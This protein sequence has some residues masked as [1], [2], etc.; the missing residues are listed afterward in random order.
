MSMRTLGDD[1]VRGGQTVFHGLR[2]WGQL[3][4]VGLLLTAFLTVAVPAVQYLRTVPGYHLYAAGMLTLAEAKLAMGYGED[5][6]QE[7]LLENGG[8]AVA[9]L[10]DIAGYAPW[11]A[12]RRDILE[13]VR[14]GMWLG[15]RIGLGVVAVMLAWFR[16]QGSRLKRAKRVRGA[17]LV[18]ARALARRVRPWRERALSAVGGLPAP[19]R[20]AGVSYPVRAETQHTIVS[21]TTGSGKTVLISD[22]VQQIRD[23][24]ERCVIYD[25]MGSYT[26]A[27][28]DPAR[29]VLLNPL[30]ARAPRWSPFLEARSP[31]DFDT[32]AA[33]LI[34]QQKDTVDPFWVTA[35]RQ[36][37]ANGA[38]VL[39]AKGEE[40]N[41]ALVEHLLKTDL[42]DLAKAMEG[43]VAQSI[44]DPQNPKTALSVRAMLTANIGAMEVLADS[45]KH[46]SIRDWISSDRGSG[47]LFL[48]SR[49]DQHASLRG[50]ISTWLEIAVNSMLSLEQDEGRR[51]W[52]IL[53]ELPTLHQVP[54]LQPGLAESR[55][56]GGC[57]VLG[58]QVASALRDLYGRN[59]AET[60]SGLCGTRV[61]FAAPDRDTAQWS[62]DSLGRSEVEEFAEGVSYGA[63]PYRDGVT[64][65]PKR[66]VQALAL[67]SEIMRLPNLN[68]YLKLPGPFPVARIELEYVKREKVASRFVARGREAPDDADGESGEGKDRKSAAADAAGSGEEKKSK[69][70]GSAP[71]PDGEAPEQGSESAAVPPDADRESGTGAD[72]EPGPE[73][74]EEP[75]PDGNPRQGLIPL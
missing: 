57:F 64:L 32:M 9:T 33:A 72:K 11:H 55:Q 53:D 47:F 4:R 66:E 14:S 71:P 67:P 62:A 50:L 56:F 18:T 34:P 26:R 48:T 60:I 10:E 52:V 43:T 58:V 44:V 36:L 69:Q 49:G 20:I 2:M 31:R 3:V 29:D 39:W 8:R 17:E 54:S 46:F 15:A 30:D 6:G 70:A 21:G 25:K 61:V 19:Y 42:S 23:R 37:F 22:I 51:I 73:D 13:T 38:G 7:I 63:D 59:G 1:T 28:F 16:F 74:A 27:F 45:G 41:K 35:A 65:T 75:A 5:A 12:A 68:G 24:G 40:R